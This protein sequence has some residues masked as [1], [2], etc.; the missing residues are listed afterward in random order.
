MKFRTMRKVQLS[1]WPEAELSSS[2]KLLRL[3]GK[4]PFAGKGIIRN[5]KEEMPNKEAKKQ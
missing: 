3:T 2:E 1:L 4:R 5:E